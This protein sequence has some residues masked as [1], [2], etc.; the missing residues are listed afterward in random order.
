LAPRRFSP[1]ALSEQMS[2]EGT[3]GAAASTPAI[4]SHDRPGTFHTPVL[5]RRNAS[6]GA[7][8]QLSEIC[9]TT[10]YFGGYR[11]NAGILFGHDNKGGRCL[12]TQSS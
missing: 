8:E 3:R 1:E 7:R 10:E 4:T 11:R 2:L 6:M 5:L 12:T 9:T